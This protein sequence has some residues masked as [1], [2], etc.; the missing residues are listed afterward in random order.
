MTEQTTTPAP[1]TDAR[2]QQFIKDHRVN[3]DALPEDS[4][5]PYDK[6]WDDATSRILDK[7]GELVTAAAAEG[8]E[9]A[10]VFQEILRT[11]EALATVPDD[12]TIRT[13]RPR[14]GGSMFFTKF[15]KG[16]IALDPSD[17][18]DGEDLITPGQLLRWMSTGFAVVVDAPSG[19][20][21]GEAPGVNL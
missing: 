9:G 16:F 21:N 3:T 17:R 2:V 20:R 6:G 8:K 13:E 15:G 12:V 1:H 10:W 7:L 14:A 4:V 5:T 11:E 19:K 18:N